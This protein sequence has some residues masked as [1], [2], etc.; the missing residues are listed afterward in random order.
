LDEA[1]RGKTFIII[2]HRLSTIRDSDIIFVFEDG[3]V[4]ERGTYN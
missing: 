1:M 2:A 3:K 4:I